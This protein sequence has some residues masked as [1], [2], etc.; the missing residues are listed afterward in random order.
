MSARVIPLHRF[1]DY[2]VTSQSASEERFWGRALRRA[3]PDAWAIGPNRGNNHAQRCGTDWL[4]ALPNNT[5]RRIECKLRRKPY[6][7]YPD[8]LLEYVANDSNGTPGWIEL[9]LQCDELFY[10]WS[11]GRVMRFDFVRLQT[12]WLRHKTEWLGHMV[13]GERHGFRKSVANNGRYRTLGCVVPINELFKSL[14][15]DLD[16]VVDNDDHDNADEVS[17]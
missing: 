11:C 9:P 10:G 16:F 1:D 7:E 17:P 15:H 12:A 8:V 13:A 4:V 5:T 2:L 3:F 14:R 6:A